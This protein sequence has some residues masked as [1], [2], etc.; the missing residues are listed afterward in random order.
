LQS[1]GSIE[2]YPMRGINSGHPAF[3]GTS[4]WGPFLWFVSL[5]KQKNRTDFIASFPAIPG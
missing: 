3:G 2:E 5:G 1:P 4:A